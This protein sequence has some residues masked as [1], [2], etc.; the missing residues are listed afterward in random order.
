MINLLRNYKNKMADKIYSMLG[1]AQKAGKLVSGDETCEVTIKSN[2]CYL[3]I[4]AK[5]AS[6]RTKEKFK[7][8]CCFRDVKILEYGCKDKIGSYIG[9]GVRSVVGLKD[10]NFAKKIEELIEQNIKQNGG[11]SI[12]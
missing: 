6:E 3:V 9:K 11:E 7:K 4:I 1:L 2:K 8:I 12:G 5:D 10:I